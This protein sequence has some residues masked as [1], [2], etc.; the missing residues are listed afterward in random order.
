MPSLIDYNSA[1]PFTGK[2]VGTNGLGAGIDPGV[3]DG[4]L[5]SLLNNKS[6]GAGFSAFG[7]LAGAAG[8]VFGGFQRADADEAR[9]TGY[10]LESQ[11]YN[12][13][14]GFASGNVDIA[15]EA[16]RI[17]AYQQQRTIDATIGTQ[18][19]QVGNAGFSQSGTALSLLR[20]S[21]A[22]GALATG[23][24]NVQGETQAQGYRAQV[25]S[26]T[27]L[28]EKS[29]DAAEAAKSAESSDIFGGLL[30]GA[31]G[32]IKAAAAILPLLPL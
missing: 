12:T 29:K 28:A 26:D 18:E 11:A 7:D 25:A 10:E 14:A 5:D 30:G 8:S 2:G 23:L 21:M 17:K 22:Q 13:A 4:T 15:E 16:K 6:V 19:A 31:G 24:V 9:A 20:S 3:A 32:I 27:L 1:S